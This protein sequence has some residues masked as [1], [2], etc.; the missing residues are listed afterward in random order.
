MNIIIGDITAGKMRDKY[1][2]LPLQDI[3]FHSHP[4]LPAVTSYCLVENIP[5]DELPKLQ[6][7]VDLHI[8]F[9]ENLQKPDFNYCEQAL[10]HLKG[11]WGGEVDSYYE[12]MEQT[13]NKYK[14]AV[15]LEWDPILYK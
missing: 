9:Y 7:Q 5:I 11:K 1:T 8:K 15:D 14:N 3:K 6:E 10:E 4:D 2:V 13:I 12:I